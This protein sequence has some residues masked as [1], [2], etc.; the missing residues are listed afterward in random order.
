MSHSCVP[1]RAS[2]GTPS[3]TSSRSFSEEKI[4]DEERVLWVLVVTSP[5]PKPE[6]DSFQGFHS[7]I[8]Q[9]E[10][11]TGFQRFHLQPWLGFKCLLSLGDTK[12]ELT[13]G[14]NRS[15]TETS[16]FVGL[17]QLVSTL[18]FLDEFAANLAGIDSGDMNAANR[19]ATH[20]D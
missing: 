9:V 13:S 19:L 16:V 11:L 15:Q 1:T 20:V 4:A 12:L 10:R 2:R 6:E 17:R 3:F 18:Q 8:A 5:A 14:H 7:D